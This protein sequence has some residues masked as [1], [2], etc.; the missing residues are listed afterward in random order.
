M[1]CYRRLNWNC[2]CLCADVMR[3]EIEWRGNDLV[4]TEASFV[5]VRVV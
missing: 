2:V 1:R 3:K 4:Q 5:G